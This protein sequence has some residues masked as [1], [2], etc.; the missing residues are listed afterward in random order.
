MKDKGEL[1]R[2]KGC[3]REEIKTKRLLECRYVEGD[4]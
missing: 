2:R 4:V 1:E 3:K